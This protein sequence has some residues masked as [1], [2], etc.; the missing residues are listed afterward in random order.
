[1]KQVPSFTSCLV[2]G[3]DARDREADPELPRGM[4]RCPSCQAVND[5]IEG[6]APVRDHPRPVFSSPASTA[7]ALRVSVTRRPRRG[8]PYRGIVDDPSPDRVVVRWREPWGGPV[9][10][11]VISVGFVIAG[12]FHPSSSPLLATLFAIA[13]LFTA[14]L[15]LVALTSVWRLVVDGGRVELARRGLPFH[16]VSTVI[17]LTRLRHCQIVI[18]ETE[19][20]EGTTWYGIG[21]FDDED[22]YHEQILSTEPETVRIIVHA[23]AGHVPRALDGAGHPLALE[24]GEDEGPSGS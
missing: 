7:L 17:P 22:G 18:R 11:L 16:R 24:P 8:T 15:S 9:L 14:S 13:A 3:H 2:C 19:S 21:W 1:M 10:G 20:V 6:I 23:I 5:T 4:F 12:L